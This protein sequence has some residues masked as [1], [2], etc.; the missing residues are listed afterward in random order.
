MEVIIAEIQ[1]FIQQI[2]SLTSG[3]TGIFSALVA[4]SL[5]GLLFSRIGR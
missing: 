4:L 5:L 2:R 3:M 1:Q